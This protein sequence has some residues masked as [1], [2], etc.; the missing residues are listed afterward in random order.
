MAEITQRIRNAWNAFMG[1]DPTINRAY[2]YGGYGGI[3]PI[4]K[5][6]ITSYRSIM[7]IIYNRIAVDCAAVNVQH[8]RVDEND[9][10]KEIIDDDLNWVLTRSANVDQTGREF[11]RDIVISMLDEG[12]V[13]VVPFMTDVDPN[14]NTTF[15][16]L[17]A[18]TGKITKWYPR[19][20]D[21]EVYDENTGTKKVLRLL[22]KRY[23][24]IIENPFYYIMNEPNSVG[25]RLMRT[26][27]QL[28]HLNDQASSGKLDLII[29]LPY[30]VKTPAKQELAESRRKAVEAQLTNSVY[31]IAYIDSTERVIQLNRSLENNL[32]NQAK[33]LMEELFNQT[34]LTKS[35]FD[36]TADEATLLNYN[37]RT[38]EPILTSV[39]EQ[40]EKAWLSKTAIRQGQRIRFFKDPF[41]LVPVSQ[42]AEIAD[43]FTRNEIMTSNEIRSVVGMKPSS[44]PKA[45]MLINA[46]LN[47]S[48]QA[49][50]ET[51]GLP[52]NSK[53]ENEFEKGQ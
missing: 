42:I 53:S 17:E 10:Y 26:L 47:Q 29:Q 18:R 24:P 12:V 13:A 51:K 35:I 11:I 15:N 50:E 28:D 8:V 27:T 40:M 38:I 22:Q 1:R 49:E 43:K 20:I 36:G 21:A 41:K 25:Q 14:T 46:N 7:N 23:T 16:I 48:K 44:D 32:W 31:G 4:K 34:G 9:R 45:D 2:Q 3:S 19:E 30:T 39:V 6:N 33:E 37:N 5:L 52:E